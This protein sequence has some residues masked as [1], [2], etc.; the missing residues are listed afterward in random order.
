[1]TMPKIPYNNF[2]N[3]AKWYFWQKKIQIE[4][5]KKEVK[6][7]MKK[8][9]KQINSENTSNLQRFILRRKKWLRKRNSENINNPEYNFYTRTKWLFG[10]IKNSYKMK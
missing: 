5:R 9:L 7:E 8:C 2:G 6:K 10:G 3:T 4:M 1:M